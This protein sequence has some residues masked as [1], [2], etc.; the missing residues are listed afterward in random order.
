MRQIFWVNK[1]HIKRVSA[2]NVIYEAFVVMVELRWGFSA[3]LA[4]R[5]GKVGTR[6]VF[7]LPSFSTFSLLSRKAMQGSNNLFPPSKQRLRKS[8]FLLKL[9]CQKQYW[10]QARFSSLVNKQVANVVVVTNDTIGF[11]LHHIRLK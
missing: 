11:D 10:D 3:L 9:S 5:K 4:W 1:I 8:Q 7:I 2:E 6:K